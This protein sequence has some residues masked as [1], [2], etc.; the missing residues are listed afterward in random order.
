[1]SPDEAMEKGGQTLRQ[2]LKKEVSGTDHVML[3]SVF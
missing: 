3:S 2:E 1:M